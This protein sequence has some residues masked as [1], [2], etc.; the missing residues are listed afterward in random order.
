MSCAHG[1][2]GEPRLCSPALSAGLRAEFTRE[3]STLHR[4]GCGREAVRLGARCQRP[5]TAAV[6]GGIWGSGCLQPLCVQLRVRLV[7]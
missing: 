5:S 7:F 3:P 2:L 6:P 1:A 4:P